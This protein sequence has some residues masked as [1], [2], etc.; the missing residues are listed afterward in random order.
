MAIF[1]KQAPGGIF[2][3]GCHNREREQIIVSK[4]GWKCGGGGVRKILLFFE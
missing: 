4:N 1:L 3:Y 2:A